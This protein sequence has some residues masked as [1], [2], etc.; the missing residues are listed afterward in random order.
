MTSWRHAVGCL[1]VL[2]L[3]G[4]P[5]STP[6]KPLESS[7]DTK[8]IGD[9]EKRLWD[10]SHDFD[11]AMQKS[12]QVLDD[13]AAT[14]YLQEI[15]DRL[16]PEFRG[17]IRVKIARSPHLNAFA[18][19]NGSIYFHLGLLARL[20]NEA[21]LATVLAHEGAHFV[22][23]HSFQQRNTIISSSLFATATAL[24]GIPIIGD[25]IANS[26]IY[27]FSR[28][29]ERDAD[30]IGYERL[31]KAG[32]D[33]R[34][35]YKA[36]EHLAAEVRALE[37]KEPFFFSTHPKFEERII[38]YKELVAAHPPG[39]KDRK[40]AFPRGNAVL[41]PRMFEKRSVHESIQKC[42]IGP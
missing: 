26:S 17:A 23:K 41:T 24:V 5:A 29:L 42:D 21:Q 22:R 9:E 36:F 20:D 32:Y 39:G 31:L 38:S 11:V 1:F 14:R 37:I 10:G 35:S 13:P 27:G 12:G 4:C 34:E 18:L 6:V 30:R 2:L 16:Y 3:V 33:P 7:E 25:V 28:D 40:S 15:M 19:P 8:Y